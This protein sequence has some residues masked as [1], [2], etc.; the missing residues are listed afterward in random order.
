MKTISSLSELEKNLREI[1]IEYS[2]LDGKFVLNALSLYGTYLSERNKNILSGLTVDDVM[3]L[4]ELVSTQSTNNVSQTI[5]NNVVTERSYEL[6]LMSYGNSAEQVMIKLLSRLYTQ[7]SR[8]RLHSLGIH[9]YDS[10]EFISINDYINETM[11]PRTDFSI[12]FSCEYNI[13]LPQHVEY[14][15]E[16]VSVKDV[17]T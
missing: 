13:E 2:E 7:E 12:K 4:F 5:N 1:L 8:N 10:S 11:F 14:E 16:S 15:F 6:K 3:L 9:L 17:I